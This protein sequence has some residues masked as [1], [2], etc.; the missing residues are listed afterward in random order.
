MGTYANL[1][2]QALWE[3]KDMTRM[4]SPSRGS[5][6]GHMTS[7]GFVRLWEGRPRITVATL[8]SISLKPSQV[9]GTKSVWKTETT[10]PALTVYVSPVYCS[11]L[12]TEIQSFCLQMQK[13]RAT[14]YLQTCQRGRESQSSGIS[15]SLL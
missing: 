8:T 10:M 15:I 3:V 4:R 1:R 6:S 14:M 7:L 12:S 9:E 13:Q 11:E 5:T 2:Q